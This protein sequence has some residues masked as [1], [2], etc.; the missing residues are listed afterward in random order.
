[1]NQHEQ[2]AQFVDQ[3]C[4]WPRATERYGL[5]LSTQMYWAVPARPSVEEI[6]E[7]WIASAEFQALRLGR[8][9]GTT[10]GKVITAAVEMISPPLI[11]SDIELLVRALA[12]AAELQ[13]EGQLRRARQVALGTLVAAVMLF[14]IG[15]WGRPRTA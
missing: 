10:D 13:R 2:I 6:A 15:G 1:M 7:E 4:T 12:Y 11:K 5:T 3:W 9:L 14:G 8:W